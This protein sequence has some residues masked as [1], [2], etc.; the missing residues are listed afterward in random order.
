MSR[1]AIVWLYIP[2]VLMYHTYVLSNLCFIS[3]ELK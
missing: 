3:E 2:C 1:D